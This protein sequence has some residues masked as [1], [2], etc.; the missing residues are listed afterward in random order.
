[1]EVATE[2]GAAEM[3]EKVSAYSPTKPWNL[4]SSM[5]MSPSKLWEGKDES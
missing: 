4:R 5:M 3:D 2:R 1:M